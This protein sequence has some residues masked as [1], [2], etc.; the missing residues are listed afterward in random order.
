MFVNILVVLSYADGTIILSFRLIK[1]LSVVYLVDL[2]SASAELFK[3]SILDS[4]SAKVIYNKVMAN[5][6]S[7]KLYF[8]VISRIFPLT[9]HNSAS[10]SC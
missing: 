8:W 5:F 7:Y 9:H 6:I 2:R 1:L 10:L 4:K 3:M